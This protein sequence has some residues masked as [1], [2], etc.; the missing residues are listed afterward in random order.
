MATALPQAALSAGAALEFASS[1]VATFLCS[2]I[3]TPTM[4]LTNRIM[5][6]NYPNLVSAVTTIS[7][8]S[9]FMGFYAGWWPGLVQKVPSYGLN[10]VF[11]Q[12]FKDLHFR[13]S[14]RM[15]SDSENFWIACASAACTCTIMIPMD[16]C[17]RDSLRFC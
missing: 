2:G 1:S 4:V 14:Q 3:S 7:Q 17:V 15:P 13:I 10:W 6:G 8:K 16:R 12:Q 11:F 5:A 9:G